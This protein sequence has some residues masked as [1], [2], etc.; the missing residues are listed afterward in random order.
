MISP[1]PQH[2]ILCFL[3]SHR[4]SPTPSQRRCP[5]PRMHHLQIWRWLGGGLQQAGRGCAAA[6]Q[7]LAQSQHAQGSR[8]PVRTRGGSVDA[9]RAGAAAASNSPVHGRM[10]ASWSA[11]AT[12]TAT[13]LK[14]SHAIS[15]QLMA[16]ISE[17][18]DI[19]L[20]GALPADRARNA[21]GNV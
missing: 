1:T 17:I 13:L 21:R 5:D 18:E 14:C 11:T 3:L 7:Q 20:V 8:S 15:N 12:A 16:L 4:P 19:K 6:V 10:V 9:Q 2:A